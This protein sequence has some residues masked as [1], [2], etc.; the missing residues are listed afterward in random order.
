MKASIVAITQ[1]LVQTAEGDRALTAE[2]YLI[3]T[4]RISSPQNQLNVET[5]PK[6][7]KYL[8]E[9]AHW[10]PFEQV[11]VGFEVQTSRAIAAQL[12][13]HKSLSFQEFS[14]RY[15][16]VSQGVESSP[17]RMKGA[18][19]RQGSL[20]DAPEYI[21]E[22]A[23]RSYEEALKAY[24]NLLARGVAPESARMVLPLATT[25]TLIVTGSVRSF[26]HYFEQR[27]HPHTQKEHRLLAEQ[28][29]GLLIS[30]FP[31]LSEA[32]GWT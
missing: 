2:E 12:L 13:R 28:M 15:S 31:N 3:Y 11:S 30:L 1:P 7:L 10:S 4:A 23:D 16:T 5:A 22:I 27:C 29:R 17:M 14:Q 6:L 9:H 19:N 18:T 32:L 20:E 24:D 21:Q 26:V 25:S 8:I